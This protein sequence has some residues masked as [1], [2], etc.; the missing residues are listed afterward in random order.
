MERDQIIANGHDIFQ[1]RCSGCHGSDAKGTGPAAVMLSPKPRNLAEGLFKLRSTA[2]G[3]MPTTADLLRTINQGVPGSS[4]PSFRDVPE[5]EKSAI[6]AFI[7]SL[8]QWE[9]PGP[10][11]FME[12][13]Q[14]PDSIFKTKASLLASAKAG[15]DLFK[16][17]CS[18]CHGERGRGDGTSADALVDMNEQPIRPANLSAPF[19]KSGSTARDLY[20]AISTGLDGSPMPSYAE[21][22]SPEARWKIVAFILYLRAERLGIYGQNERVAVEGKQAP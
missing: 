10:S 11:Q 21:A 22:Y 20:K 8:R 5:S 17:G 2:G 13:P 15:R 12:I 9:E 19:V 1:R 4:M 16:E 14:P 18:A 6:I 3:A 7:K